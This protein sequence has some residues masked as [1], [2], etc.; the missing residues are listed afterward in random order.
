MMKPHRLDNI[1]GVGRFII[2]GRMQDE[3]QKYYPSNKISNTIKDLNEK[4]LK[5][6]FLVGSN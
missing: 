4:R 6:T 5:Y 3:N 1:R 2:L